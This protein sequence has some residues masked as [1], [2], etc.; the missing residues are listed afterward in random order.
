MDD[1]QSLK[2]KV[3]KGSI[4]AI[5]L[6]LFGAIFAYLIRV[7]YSRTLSIESY[8]LFYAIFGFFSI[9]SSYADLGFGE[10]ISFF[11][12]KHLKRKEFGKLWNTFLY[13][14]IIQVAVSFVMAL[15]LASAAP[16]LA[17]NYFKVAGSE[18]IIYIFCIFMILNSFLNG[19]NQIFTGL[20]KE[21]YFSS[22]NTTK[23][24][25]ILLFSLTAVYLGFNNVN[26]YGFIWLIGYAITVII[27]LYLLWTKHTFLTVNIFTLNKDIFQ[28]LL[29]YAMPAFMTTFIYSLMTATNTFFLTLF[30]GVLEVGV[31]NVVVPIAS[32]SMIFL[33]PLHN[34]L[35]PLTSNLMEGE[36]EKMGY[37]LN[38]LYTVI[39]Y[40]GIYF[41]LF[42]VI[43]SNSITGIIFGEKWVN[44]TETPLI[45]LS[46]G[47]IILLLSDMLG[48][49]AL[50]M[51]R[52]KERLIILSIVGFLNITIGAIFIW[53][54]GILGAVLVSSF[55][56]I[57]SV[58]LFTK[59]IR[60]DVF[61]Q[62]PYF[63]YLK[64]FFFSA[65]IFLMTK[66]ANLSPKNLP[67]LI[68]HGIFYTFIFF[69]FG[70]ILKI[71][72]KK[73]ISMIIPFKNFK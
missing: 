25:F 19:I 39:P 47:L 21:T 1:T 3:V 62:I 11:I 12:P 37:L 10:A 63:F 20:Q 28:S 61:F 41:G 55:I 36:K 23:T 29:K 16:F 70:F 49:I 52:I 27:Y 56:A 2:E 9:L 72:D 6:T 50:G 57:L 7:I 54:Y 69:L 65:S 66:F 30:R 45:I 32:T 26:S 4:V 48:T 53:K 40:L 8:G 64:L 24:F 58:V 38:R 43:F 17:S 13:G 68:L 44:L 71:Y 51:G 34:V 59:M 15:I 46:I 22:I 60:K 67:E 14:Q 18:I 35:L 73:I 5:V 33:A 31:Y 42:I